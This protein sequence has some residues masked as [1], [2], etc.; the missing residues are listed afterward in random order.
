MIVEKG[1]SDCA[2]DGNILK[3]YDRNGEHVIGK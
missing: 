3:L 1:L 2:C